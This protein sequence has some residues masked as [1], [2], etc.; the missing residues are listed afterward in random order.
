MT[1]IPKTEQLK[2]FIL[3]WL[4]AFEP[5]EKAERGDGVVPFQ[6]SPYDYLR[7]AEEELDKNT[8]ASRINCLQHLRRAAECALDVFLWQLGLYDVVRK[9]NLGFDKKMDFIRDVGLF[10]ARSLSRMNTIR[11][12]VEHWYE[13]PS[14][15]DME[16]YYDLVVALVE[17]IMRVVFVET[18][19]EMTWDW[20][21]DEAVAFA[22]EESLRTDAHDEAS[23][24]PRPSPGKRWSLKIVYDRTEPSITYRLIRDNEAAEIRSTM[25]N[26]NEFAFFLKLY[27]LVQ[28]YNEHLGKEYIRAKLRE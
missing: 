19:G 18:L 20:R 22:L 14:V 9:R 16:V 13:I 27:L 5:P 11:N 7:F 4:E 28:H 3:D 23:L 26:P 6:L 12:R 8:V 17:V 15:E 10:N 21:D 24:I 1:A 25:E 2:Q